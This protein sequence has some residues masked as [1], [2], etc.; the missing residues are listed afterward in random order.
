MPDTGNMYT[1]MPIQ[2]L[3]MITH[4][5]IMRSTAQSVRVGGFAAEGQGS[6]PMKSSCRVIDLHDS[7]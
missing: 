5:D 2:A 4:V 6:V 1:S 7:V 3:P